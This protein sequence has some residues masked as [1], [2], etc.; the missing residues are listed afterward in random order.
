MEQ[1]QRP[2]G[3]QSDFGPKPFVT[4]ICRVA[5]ENHKFR[6]ALWTGCHLQL[7]VMCIPP[8]GE[9]G[10]EMHPDTDQFIR[11]EQGRGLMKMGASGEKMELCRPV[12][13]GDAIFVP[14]G[15]WHNLVNTGRKTMKLYTIYA[16]PHHPHGTIHC[17]KAEAASEH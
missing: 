14:A 13:C 6:R 8:W 17:T 16:P 1:I 2:C 10:L 3:E 7:T 11:L 4:D 12:R 15:T 9:I 5:A